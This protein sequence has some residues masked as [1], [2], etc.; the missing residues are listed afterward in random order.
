MRAY[1]IK[2]LGYLV[3]LSSVLGLSPLAH[4]QPDVRGADAAQQADEHFLKGKSLLKGGNVRGAYEEYKTSWNLKRTY[5]IAANLGNLEL[6][7]GMPRD[8]AEHLAFSVRNYAI[9]GTTPERLDKTKQLLAQARAQVTA[10][11][12][13]VNVDGAEV[14][15]DGKV[16]GRAPIVEEVYVDGL[17]HDRGAARQLSDGPRHRQRR[18]GRPPADHAQARGARSGARAHGDLERDRPAASGAGPEQAGAHRWGH[19][20]GCGRRTRRRVRGRLEQQGELRQRPAGDADE[21]GH[22]G[23]LRNRPR[24]L[25]GVHAARRRRERSTQL[26]Q[27][28]RLELRRWRRRGRGDGRLLVRHAEERRPGQ[29]GR[30]RHPRGGPAGC[31]PGAS[32]NVV[33]GHNVREG[34]TMRRV[35]HMAGVGGLIALGAVVTVA[36]C[37]PFTEGAD[38]A[39]AFINCPTTSS[40]TSSSSMAASSSS[41]GTGGSDGGHMNCDPTKGAIDESCGMFVN[42]SAPSGGTGTK[43]SPYSSLQ[44][45]VDNAAG[46]HVY[47]C[48]SAPFTEAVTISASVELWG[49]FADCTTET[50]WSWSQDARST[51]NGP[52]DAVALTVAKGADGTTV[53]GFA[54]VAGAPSDPMGGGS[55]IAVAVADVAATFDHCDV[56][57]KDG[58]TGP[59]GQTPSGMPV[60]GGTG[61]PGATIR[62]R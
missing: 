7:L 48:A 2:T 20:G 57:A 62:A 31:Q 45:A 41:S 52:A 13:H 23:E 26:R 12:I 27:R 36:G 60:V 56:T 39:T 9:T 24:S 21:G 37:W 11:T 54:I 15:I 38:C 42:A 4:S 3:V 59:D 18:E 8:A 35:I 43:T 25:L 19:R 14:A 47:A 51:L 10:L 49:G 55:S 1:G 58:A 40:T 6:S 30:A 33:T 17:A 29:A 32:R 50:G 28:F 5:D 22:A 61:A 34:Q 53:D 44:A 46:K 16:V